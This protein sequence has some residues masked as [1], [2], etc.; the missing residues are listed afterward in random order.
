VSS[1][2]GYLLAR[3]PVPP[4]RCR[5]WGWV[6]TARGVAPQHRR[7]LTMPATRPTETRWMALSAASQRDDPLRD[8]T[9]RL[10]GGAAQKVVQKLIDL[11]LVE[12]VH[13]RGTLPVWRR[14]DDSCPWRCVTPAAA[15]NAFS[16]VPA[17]PESQAAAPSSSSSSDP[18]KRGGAGSIAPRYRHS[19]HAGLRNSEATGSG[20]RG[21]GRHISHSRH[22]PPPG[23]GG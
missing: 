9:P 3:D 1:S 21:N 5:S 8:A 16:S 6:V 4:A 23:S 13:A 10:R 15:W 14:E 22:Y 19:V 11:G 18:A 7:I 17:S 2:L 12:A 20:D